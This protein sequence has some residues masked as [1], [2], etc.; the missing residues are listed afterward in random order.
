MPSR[1]LG[2]RISYLYALLTG[3]VGLFTL[4]W[5]FMHPVSAVD[6]ATLLGF[7]LFAI[8]LSYLRIPIGRMGEVGL[9]GAVLLGA[10]LL[11][12]PA[13][14]GWAGFIAGLVAGLIPLPAPPT[15]GEQWASRAATALFDGGRN[16]LAIAVAWWAYQGL[17]GSRVPLSLDA[18]QTLAV[19][20][21]CLTYASVRCLWLWILLVLRRTAAGQL[22]TGLLTSSCFLAEVLPLPTAVLVAA[23]F[24]WLGWPYFLLLAFLFIGLSA[25][26]HRMVEVLHALQDE[27]TLL[28]R[29]GQIKDRI[30]GAPQAIASLS[31]LAYEIC[32]QIAPSEKFELGLYDASCTHVYIQVSTE[33]DAR[34]PPMHIPITPKWEWLSELAATQRLNDREQIEQLPFSL[35]PLGKDRAPR[36][37]LFVPILSP[38]PEGAT[39]PEALPDA[40]AGEGSIDGSAAREGTLPSPIGAM[41]LLSTQPKAFNAREAYLITFLAAQLAPALARAGLPHGTITGSLQD[42]E[43]GP[44]A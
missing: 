18:T 40:A 39:V 10:A 13:W 24:V 35:P 23:T 38:I 11:G 14:G 20:V 17:G 22:G 30:A 12:G 5:L 9:T 16:I 31:S 29:T 43:Q 32:A 8:L 2:Q 44:D 4:I 34:L 15:G 3:L 21:L 27:V 6:L 26:M 19:I 33:D 36:S 1:S 28:R 37:A 25:L 41:V 42:S 7:T